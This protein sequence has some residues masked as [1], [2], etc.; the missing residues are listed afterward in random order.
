MT[1]WFIGLVFVKAEN[2][3]VDL[4]FDIQNFTDIGRLGDHFSFIVCP[5]SV[6]SGFVLVLESHGIFVQVMESHGI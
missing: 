6:N 4:T 5:V 1:K 2:V 3:N